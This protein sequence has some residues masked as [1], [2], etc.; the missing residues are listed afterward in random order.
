MK[1]KL[2]PNT[3]I[4]EIKEILVLE[5]ERSK[6]LAESHKEEMKYKEKVV[7]EK[8]EEIKKCTLRE[9]EF[10]LEKE[11]W[12]QQAKLVSAR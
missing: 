7:S 4:D 9:E 5:Q 12:L 10:R 8:I 11:K 2:M 3:E 1:E 6:L